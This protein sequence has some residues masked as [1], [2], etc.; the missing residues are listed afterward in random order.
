[1][2]ELGKEDRTEHGASEVV[3]RW[4]V[5][6]SMELSGLKSIGSTLI[7]LRARYYENKDHPMDETSKDDLFRALL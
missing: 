1:M 6:G 4:V 7:L 5:G 2:S 3:M